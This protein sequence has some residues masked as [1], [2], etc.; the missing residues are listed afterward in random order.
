[1]VNAHHNRWHTSFAQLLQPFL[2]FKSFNKNLFLFFVL[3]SAM[4]WG[5]YG[6]GGYGWGFPPMMMMPWGKGKGKVGLHVIP[7]DSLVSLRPSCMHST[8]IKH[9][10]CI[11]LLCVLQG[12][13][14]L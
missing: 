13:K 2:S 7:N 8:P 6:K 10:F 1:M 11:L 3:L 4:G 5:G 14:D 12:S 9:V